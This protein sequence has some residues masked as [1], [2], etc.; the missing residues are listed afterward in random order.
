MAQPVKYPPAVQETQE[1]VGSIPGS[2][3][4]L[5]GGHGNPLQF[6]CLE[7]SMDREAWRATVR[8]VT[9]VEHN[10]ATKQRQE[11]KKGVF[12]T[13]FLWEKVSVYRKRI[14]YLTTLNMSI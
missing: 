8:G 5:G 9:K 10:L 3:R 7:N 1:D 4:S 11:W 13:S 14:L 12:S 2:G 6:S